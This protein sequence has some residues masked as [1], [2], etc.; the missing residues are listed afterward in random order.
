VINL[1]I[2]IKARIGFAVMLHPFE[3]NAN[4]AQEIFEKSLSLLKS[5]DS[6]EIITAD[7]F[8]NEKDA[9]KLVGK[10]FNNVKV[11]V[12]CLKLA[13]WS[14]DDLL[15]ELLAESDV[16]IILWAYPHMHAGSLGGAQQFN[17]VLKEVG[18]ECKF[19]YGDTQETLN[20]IT[21]YSN[22]IAV[23][24]RLKH[25]IIGQI[26]DRTQG[27]REVICDE[28]SLKRIF[29][30]SISR[31][32]LNEF[33]NMNV[34]VSE[35]EISQQWE[36]VKSSIEK[37]NI[38]EN[39]GLDAIRIFYKLKNFIE[40]DNL[41]ALTIECY[42][43]FMGKTCLGFSLL[44]DEG[45]ACACEGDV[46]GALLMWIMMKL[47]GGPVHNT[48]TLYVH[49]EDNS[50]TSSHCGCGSINL[51]ES[52]GKIEISP[53]RLV[54]E[55]ACVVFP[56][57]PGIVTMA[58]L[59]G[60]AETYRLGVILGEAIKTEMTFPGNP[61]RV[62]LPASIKDYLKFIEEYALGHHWIVTY[63]D[64]TK[65]LKIIAKLLNIKIHQLESN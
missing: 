18:K 16:P 34:G 54:D 3:E 19:V 57:K 59:V 24:N 25:L 61:L 33:V 60:K 26:G 53:V 27:M 62:K 43:K 8:I 39:T 29:G 28:S 41:D 21:S 63:G 35:D 31:I 6:A 45:I 9:A 51:A 32:E 2:K 4:K 11:D 40:K 50:V 44:A 1:S 37:I 46:H 7:E 12:I 42:P 14:S 65:E 56:S 55:G 38:S 13:T 36:K 20:V 5:I 58:N 64:I 52:R 22:A 15:F 10:Q 30:A 47:S 48:D 23:Q 49:E 17:C